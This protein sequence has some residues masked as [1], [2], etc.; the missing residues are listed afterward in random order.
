MRHTPLHEL[1]AP[2]PI[3]TGGRLRLAEETWQ[4]TS[5]RAAVPL[6]LPDRDPARAELEPGVL[7]RVTGRWDGAQLHPETVELTSRRPAE[8]TGLCTPDEALAQAAL[9]RQR[10]RRRVRAY[11]E[12]RD[13]VEVQTPALVPEP[14]TDVHLEA[15]KA[16]FVPEGAQAPQHTHD[17]SKVEGAL[18]AYL[19]TSP[20][21][22]MK[23]LLAQGLERIWQIT[24]AWRNG[25]VTDRHA[26]EFG[27]LEFYRAWEDVEVIMGDVEAL[28]R[29]VLQGQALLRTPEDDRARVIELGERF[30]RV[31]M[32]ELVEE[33]CGFDI[34]EA[35]HYADLIEQVR[36]R[37]LLPEPE[38]QA[39]TPAPGELSV[40]RQTQ[41]M[42]GLDITQPLPQM[43]G[44]RER[45]DEL[46]FE[47]QIT[48][49][50]P[51][52]E[53]MGPVFV[54]QWPAP[55]A[56][57]AERDPDD[58]RVARR[59]ELFVGGVELANGFQELRDPAEQRLRF[60]EDLRRRSLHD[61]PT[62]PM[63]R[64]LLAALDEGMPPSAGVAV[65]L[66]R[67]LMLACGAATLHE[68]CPLALWR[69]PDT[70]TIQWG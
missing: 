48:H 10:M 29:R 45:W 65:G 50:D 46:F 63:P 23:R 44:Q 55:L 69:D 7:A 41:K 31:T 60:E 62:Y 2:G 12:Q 64:R 33:A 68:V 40:S 18:P 1:G 22:A 17:L 4:L 3:R 15:F 28:C 35:L 9:A 25:E 49:L 27:I 24:R 32:R 66:D 47:L 30:E 21:F 39:P 43:T 14:G 59:F 20:E 56:V 67:L 37:G 13:F 11:F 5:A 26:P 16:W 57:L 8:P 70:A 36:S 52:L 38:L 42:Y 53:R 61:H 34:L 6:A 51:L 58:E 54:T 19:Q